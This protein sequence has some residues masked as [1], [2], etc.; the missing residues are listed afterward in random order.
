MT[1][2]EGVVP[3]YRLEFDPAALSGIEECLRSGWLTTGPKTKEFEA[4]FAAALGVSPTACVALNSCTAALHL[5]LEAVGVRRGDAVIVPTMTFAATAEVVRY[6]DAVPIFADCE[7]D[8]LNL[9]IESL[10]RIAREFV[11]GRPVPG[12]GSGPRGVL[13]AIVP[14]HYGGQP[15]D[16]AGVT[17]VAGEHGAAVVEDAAHAFPAG[18]IAPDGSRRLIGS[19][20]SRVT[21]FSFYANK[22]ITTGEGGMAVAAEPEL[23]DRMRVMS[24]HGMSRNAWNRYSEA[25]S[26]DYDLVAPGFKYNLTDIAAAIGLAQLARAEEFRLARERIVALYDRSFAGMG[27]VETVLTRPGIL[28]ARHLYVL[29]L[30]LDRLSIDRTRFLAELKERGILCSVH[31]RPLHMHQYYKETYNYRPEDF[32]AAA[33]LWPRL[34]S[35]PLFPSMTDAE[36]QRVV[37]AVRDVCVRFGSHLIRAQAG[38]APHRA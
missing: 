29:K 7:P 14:V 21:C 20:T 11:E 24:L 28:H 31:W 15:C 8:T 36:I 4:R 32:P 33:S 26:W 17:R 16:L 35:L 10:G 12:L 6:F 34:V 5:A 38:A 13:R 22:T 30:N 1:R 27:E 2:A 25:G 19:G 3:F 23:A 9:S 37:E 18:W